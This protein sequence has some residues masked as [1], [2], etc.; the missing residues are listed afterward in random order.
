MEN[1]EIDEFVKKAVLKGIEQ[2]NLPKETNK[3][4]VSLVSDYKYSF[5]NP[6]NSRFYF[7]YSREGSVGVGLKVINHS[8]LCLEE[9]KGCR[10][11]IKKYLI[12]ITNKI[13]SKRLFK[14]EGDIDKRKEL[15]IEAVKTL[16]LESIDVLKEFIKEY[17]GSSDYI[18]KKVWIADNKILHDK[19]IDTLPIEQT[20]RNE[21]VKKVYK[22]LPLSVEYSDPSYS[23]NAFR[24]L[25]LYD[26]APQI[27]DEISNLNSRFIEFENRALIPLTHQIELHLEVQRET[28]STLKAI[29]SSVQEG[30]KNSIIHTSPN[31]AN[32]SFF[33]AQ[34][35]Y[36]NH[37]G[38]STTKDHT[39]YWC[40][41]CKNITR[42]I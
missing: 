28:L 37:K 12:E 27:A 20:F 4:H 31:N 3:N 16:E 41:K 2:A 5:Y 42:L 26:Y 29:K 24:N 19:I 9:Y 39:R 11:V 34:C 13:N 6:H 30:S 36:C 15:V 8:E 10:I 40:P 23:A 33:Y 7:N 18:C 32:A 17:G 14:I 1:K 35:K 38:K 25:G 22:E 21:V